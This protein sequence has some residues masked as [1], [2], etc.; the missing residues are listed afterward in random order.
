MLEKIE[1][2]I[3]NEQGYLTTKELVPEIKKTYSE[4]ENDFVEISISVEEQLKYYSEEG[5]LPVEPLDVLKLSS[6]K[7]YTK[8]KIVPYLN[9]DRIS[10][11][12]EE[13]FDKRSIKNQIDNLKLELGDSDY[14]V[15]KNW[16]STLLNKT[17]PYEM[18]EVNS[19][20]QSIRDQINKLEEL[21]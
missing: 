19:E 13:Y 4:I 9:T 12:Y 5:W 21:L 16:E 11:R 17:L 20:R 15:I 2:G 18:E 3:I 8:I 6:D 7:N 14:K 1:I 10:F